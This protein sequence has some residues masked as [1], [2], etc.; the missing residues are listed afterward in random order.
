MSFTFHTASFDSVDAMVAAC[1]MKTDKA[2]HT[3]AIGGTS[4]VKDIAFTIDWCIVKF[5][6]VKYDKITVAIPPGAVKELSKIMSIFPSAEPFIRHDS[7]SAKVTPEQ[8]A[9]INKEF[10]TGDG[11]KVHIKFDAAWTISGKMYL[12]FKLVSIVKI[13]ALSYFVDE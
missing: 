8:Q 6:P 12:S 13:G 1:S 2:R 5:K 4:T 11:C 7:I 3:I 10:N 9:R